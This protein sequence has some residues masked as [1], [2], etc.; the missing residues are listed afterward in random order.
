MFHFDVK[1]KE[2]EDNIVSILALV[3]SYHMASSLMP[4]SVSILASSFTSL[5]ILLALVI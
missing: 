3:S 1:E 4:L 5:P 2:I